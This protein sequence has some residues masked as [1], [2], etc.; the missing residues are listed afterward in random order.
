MS[1]ARGFYYAGAQNVITSL[2]S[3]DDRSTAI[4]F[5]NFYQHLSENDYAGSLYDT[6]LN[7]LKNATTA[8]ASPYYWAGFVHIGYQKPPQK[9]YLLYIL[10]AGILAISAFCFLLYRRKK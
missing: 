7:Y 4:I 9:N 6:K 1:L 2:W 5:G 8:N 3:V 10:I